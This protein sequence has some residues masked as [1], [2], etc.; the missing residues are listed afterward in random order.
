MIIET[1]LVRRADLHSV[2]GVHRAGG[3]AA[4]DI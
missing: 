2:S 3:D 1:F 4:H